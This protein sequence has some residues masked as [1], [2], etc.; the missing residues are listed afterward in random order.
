[1]E[2]P[3]LQLFFDEVN[4]ALVYFP[5]PH[6]KLLNPIVIPASVCIAMMGVNL[7]LRLV[8]QV[9]VCAA[10]K[11]LVAPLTNDFNIRTFFTVNFNQLAI[12]VVRCHLFPVNNRT[13]DWISILDGG[14][15]GSSMETAAMTTM[16]GQQC[17]AAV[18]IGSGRT[19]EHG[20]V[21]GLR[22][23]LHAATQ[24][25]RRPYF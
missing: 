16:G 2:R 3:W 1:M 24:R 9:D 15:R 14:L 20:G 7:I 11:E 17:F 25:L 12:N 5:H 13:T 4:F 18:E 22:L 6:G 10:E 21:S 19:K 23:A 8:V